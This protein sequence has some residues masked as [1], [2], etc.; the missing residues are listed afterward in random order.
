ML[1]N[2]NQHRAEGMLWV[3]ELSATQCIPHLAQR[4]RD[5]HGFV[6]VNNPASTQPEIRQLHYLLPP[7][8][9]SAPERR[10]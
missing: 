4:T 5:G 2:Y 8:K 3:A 7:Q 1:P 10:N 9:Q 6:V